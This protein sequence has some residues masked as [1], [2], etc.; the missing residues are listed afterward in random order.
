MKLCMIGNRGGHANGILDG[1]EKL[2]D[3]KL[4]G[5]C[6]GSS[7]DNIK[8]LVK[9][10]DA[11][12]VQPKPYDDY[13]Q[14]LDEQ[15][16]D[17]LSVFG[18]FERHAE[19][20]IEAFRRGIHVMT[21]K[22]AATTLEDLARL[23]RAHAEAKVHLA[24]MMGSR[25]EP[26][27]HAAWRAVQGG[28]IGTIRLME[29]RKSYKLGNRAP[30]YRK[31]TTYGGTIPWVGSHAIDWLYWF[32][33]QRFVSVSAHHSTKFN[34]DHGEAEMSGL[35][36]F[37]MTNEVFASTA[38][39]YLRPDTA[40]SHGDD[41]IRVVGTDG[42]VE[43]R[44]GEASLTNADAQGVQMLPKICDRQIFCDFVGQIEGKVKALIGPDDV[45]AVT[46]ACL[47]ARQSA[48]E[49]RVIKFG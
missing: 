2:G 24:A 16:P 1:M 15:K 19:M 10:C 48:D 38:V 4:V 6:P 26:A 33:G 42:I 46:E 21:E 13:R 39:D 12:G 22:P 43:V 49:K 44:A 40:P 18:P 47:L 25:Y 35:C 29:S 5:L 9:W 32:G 14:M 45:F 11:H 36:L 28:R 20:S 8:S 23:K 27:F 7:E 3:V 37:E 41:F 31:R 34:R 17:I 30:F